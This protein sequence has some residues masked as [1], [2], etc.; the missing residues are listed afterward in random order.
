M[1]QLQDIVRGL[2]WTLIGTMVTLTVI[3]VLQAA[4]RR[5][6][7]AAEDL[8]P[9]LNESIAEDTDNENVFQD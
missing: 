3:L 5:Q 4:F 2:G 8:G 9:I 7:T 6:W 1:C